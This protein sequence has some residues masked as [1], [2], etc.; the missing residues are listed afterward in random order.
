M[1]TFWR[2]GEP[3][4]ACTVYVY[5]MGTV[6]CAIHRLT[7]PKPMVG[8]MNGAIVIL[9]MDICIT[10]MTPKEYDYGPCDNQ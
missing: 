2:P 5:F 8:E 4:G 6:T 9:Q 10:L 1:C 3:N 7:E